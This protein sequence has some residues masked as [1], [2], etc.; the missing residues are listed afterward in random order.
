MPGVRDEEDSERA[1]S[2]YRESPSAEKFVLSVL[3]ADFERV[4]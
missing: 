1:R 4:Q 2:M 3:E